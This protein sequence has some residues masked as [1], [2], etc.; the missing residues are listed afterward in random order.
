MGTTV[1]PMRMRHHRQHF[2]RLVLTLTPRPRPVLCLCVCS[3]RSKSSEPEKEPEPGPELES[4]GLREQRLLRVKPTSGSLVCAC[5]TG[6]T[7][8]QRGRRRLHLSKLPAAV[9]LWRTACT[10]CTAQYQAFVTSKLDMSS[11]QRLCADRN[12]HKIRTYSSADIRSDFSI[13]V[14]P[15]YLPYLIETLCCGRLNIAVYRV[16]KAAI[17]S[18]TLMCDVSSHIEFV[19]PPNFGGP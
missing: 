9:F 17:N 19:S 6:W 13:Y 12:F 14:Q 15:V 18:H 5:P 7:T 16:S 1:D 4:N 10:A 2:R 3:L 11:R 8:D